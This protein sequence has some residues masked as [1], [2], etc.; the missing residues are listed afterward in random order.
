M[1]LLLAEDETELS[2]ALVAILQ[3]VLIT[4]EIP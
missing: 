2:E 4:K 1:R 3:N